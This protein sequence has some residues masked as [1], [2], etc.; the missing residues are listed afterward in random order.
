MSNLKQTKHKKG[1]TVKLPRDCHIRVV[2]KELGKTRMPTDDE[3]L[4]VGFQMEETSLM[5][6]ALHRKANP[7]LVINNIPLVVW[8]CAPL[9]FYRDVKTREE[10]LAKFSFF[11]AAI[12]LLKKY[13]VILDDPI[14]GAGCA[15]CDHDHMITPRSEIKR[16]LHK[17]IRVK[18]TSRIIR[19][20]ITR[21]D[22]SNFVSDIGKILVD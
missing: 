6:N 7:N 13:N 16:N 20:G 11:I 4:R 8:C 14:P 18:N 5:E 12:K 9:K 21:A 19:R 15:D 10:L 17:L 22:I 1:E 2:V 3:L